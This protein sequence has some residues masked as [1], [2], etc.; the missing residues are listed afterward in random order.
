MK[1]V[2][3][4]RCKQVIHCV[5]LIS[6]MFKK[7]K[8]TSD[9][10][11]NS[12]L[13]TI[14]DFQTKADLAD[15]NLFDLLRY[16]RDSHLAQKIQGYEDEVTKQATAALNSEVTVHSRAVL[17][18]LAALLTCLTN[19]DSSG[20]VLVVYEPEGAYL[21]YISLNSEDP[22]LPLLR[23]RFENP[24]KFGDH[25]LIPG[26]SAECRS[27]ILAGGTMEP[28][29][30][31]QQQLLATSSRDVTLFSCGHVIPPRNL[32]PLTLSRG[33]RGELNFS[34]EG[35]KKPGAFEE[36]GHIL[37]EICQVL[38]ICSVDYRNC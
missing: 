19:A 20:R 2:N 21:R 9:S 27:V 13:F 22:F 15:I 26:S 5:R 7:T 25:I 16:I 30:E 1:P 4:L 3:L 11:S 12:Y 17:S 36:V 37:L 8:P 10:L 18:D 6:A 24:V 34:F 35:R 33:V 23:G 32:L 14:G 31:V 38:F 29:G 28:V